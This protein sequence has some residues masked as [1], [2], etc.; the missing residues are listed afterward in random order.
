MVI[1][2]HRIADA[3]KYFDGDD[4]T[5][6]IMYETPSIAGFSAGVSMAGWSPTSAFRGALARLRC[7]RRVGYGNVSSNYNATVGA[8]E[9][10]D[11]NWGA[12]VS[13]LH[14]SGLNA[15]SPIPKPSEAIQPA[16][17]KSTTRAPTTSS[18]VTRPS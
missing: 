14:E 3:Y 17:R 4:R 9:G 8:D 11:N 6:L 2:P 7:R 16:A 18:W 13:V 10:F 15:F 5:S 1:T 12:S